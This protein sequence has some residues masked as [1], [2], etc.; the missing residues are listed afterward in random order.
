MDDDILDLMQRRFARP[1]VN[2]VIKVILCHCRSHP[3]G[4]FS[5]LVRRQTVPALKLTRARER[6]SKDGRGKSGSKQAPTSNHLTVISKFADGTTEHRAR[7][8]LHARFL[9]FY[10]L[11]L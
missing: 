8:R 10:S 11:I 5:L 6:G 4:L 3:S 2:P 7:V 9:D 1:Q